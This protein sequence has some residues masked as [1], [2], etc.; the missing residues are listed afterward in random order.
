M[1]LYLPEVQRVQSHQEYLAFQMDQMI[2]SD[3]GYL[4]HPEKKE[5]REVITHSCIYKNQLRNCIKSEISNFSYMHAL[6]E[7]LKFKLTRGPSRPRSPC[8]P[9]GPS[10]P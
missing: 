1:I 3:L 7:N 6:P 8:S 2:P 10:A 5:K 4:V 9:L